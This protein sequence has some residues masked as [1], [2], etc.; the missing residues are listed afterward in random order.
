MNAQKKPFPLKS[1]LLRSMALAALLASLGTAVSGCATALS[2]TAMQQ[3]TPGVSLAGVLD[4][5]DRYSGA[6]VLVA[7]NVIRTENRK[8]GTLLEILAYPTTDRGYADTSEPA[9]GRVMLLHPG[10]LD[11]LVFRPGRQVV[12][13]G[14]VIGHRPVTIGEVLLNEPLLQSVELN[15][16]QEPNR[17]YSPIHF[18]IGVM[19][20]F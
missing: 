5:P 7:G 2:K 9:L 20:G 17:G 1:A 14:R 3:V 8:D 18:G 19:G 13:A 10:Y 11:A 15:L 16:L 4:E 6:T 12:A